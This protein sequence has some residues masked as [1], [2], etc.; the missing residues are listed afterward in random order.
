[1]I[2][3]DDKILECSVH[4]KPC[5][6]SP[7][8]KFEDGKFDW[9]GHIDH[10]GQSVIVEIKLFD[11]VIATSN[12]SDGL[13]NIGLDFLWEFCKKPIES[14]RVHFKNDGSVKIHNGSVVLSPIEKLYT[15]MDIY[16]IL[17]YALGKHDKDRIKEIILKYKKK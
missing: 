13:P 1:M 17:E 3:I 5:E 7:I 12:K 15:E 6:K 16:N 8:K 4:T 10:I 9:C 11:K 14:V 2:S